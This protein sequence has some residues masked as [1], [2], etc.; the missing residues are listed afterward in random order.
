MESSMNIDLGQIVSSLGEE[1]IAQMGE[2]LGLDK[3][4]SVKAARS[5]AENF[6]GNKDKAIE[7]AS[8]ETGIGREILTSM[9]EKLVESAK[10]KAMDHVKDQ[11][12]QA[13]KGV[14]GKFFGR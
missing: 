6:T 8:K 10:D 14:F 13:A 11:A 4:L 5:L 7:A 12:S 2:P 3:E 9:I 1:A